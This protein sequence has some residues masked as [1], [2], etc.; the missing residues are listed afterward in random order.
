[1]QKLIL[2]QQKRKN[3]FLKAN[4]VKMNI[5]KKVQPSSE[6]NSKHMDK[7]IDKHIDLSKSLSL[8]KTPSTMKPDF[9]PKL[10]AE[11]IHLFSDTKSF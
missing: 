9:D 4:I 2:N 5:N 10:I 1:M 7:H 11:S 6:E 3:Y 8:L